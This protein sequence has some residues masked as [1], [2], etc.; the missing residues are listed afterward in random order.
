MVLKKKSVFSQILRKKTSILPNS[1][2]ENKYFCQILRVKNLYIL[3]KSL[4]AAGLPTSQP[5]SATLYPLAS[6]NL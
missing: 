3:I 5:L 1:K 4:W 6:D 2:E